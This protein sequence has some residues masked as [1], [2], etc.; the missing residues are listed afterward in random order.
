MLLISLI[1]V[2]APYVS[3]HLQKKRQVAAAKE[4]GMGNPAEKNDRSPDNSILGDHTPSLAST[5]SKKRQSPRA[6]KEIS[7]LPK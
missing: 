5:F 6:D 2:A 1:G 4:V 3:T 7:Q